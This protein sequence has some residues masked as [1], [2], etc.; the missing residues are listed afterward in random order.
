MTT[1]EPGP[2]VLRLGRR[3]LLRYAGLGAG[4]ATLAACGVSG[5][6]KKQATGTNLQKQ[7]KDYWTG[8]KKTGEVNWAQWPLYIDVGK[9]KGD[10]P[11]IDQFTA[12]TGIKVNYSE[13]IQD[14]DTFFAK[15]QPSLSAGQYSGYDVAVITNG[16]DFTRFLELGLFI[17]LDHALMPNFEKYADPT[18]KKSAYDPGNV[19][20]VPWQSG[21]TG[22]AYNT[23]KVPK[24][25][26]SYWDLWDPALK[27][28]VGM[29]ADN[30]D[31]PNPCLVAMF[32]DPQ[33]TGPTQWKQ[34]A[35]KLTQ[36]RKAGIVRQYYQQNYIN[37]L[38]TGD[39]W[40]CQA[41]SGD[42]FQ[43][44][45]SGAK[46]LKFIIPKEGAVLWT[47]NMTLLKENRNPVSSMMLID[48]YYRPKIAAEV[49]E[50]VNYIT[51][52]PAAKQFIQADADKAS[53]SNKTT[54][55]QIANSELVFPTAAD[56]SKLYRYRTLNNSELN[57][58][59]NIFEPIY[60]S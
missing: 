25:I 15:V 35:T 48:W 56:Y 19:Y 58:W 54:L 5:E 26:T 40:A 39:V 47:D 52:V 17:P 60:Q 22:I 43:A 16:I 11:S 51:P 20:S 8:K 45:E 23:K 29:F 21:I 24:P 9:S 30:E 4:M 44:L 2:N 50:Y 28:K 49:A 13:V 38:S 14:D 6:G 59:N 53:G 3:D 33:K 36:Q 37:A 1:T 18:Y 12:A 7:I 42:I 10:H 27:G 32:G 34:A 41:W 46:D 31:L 55:E 57:T